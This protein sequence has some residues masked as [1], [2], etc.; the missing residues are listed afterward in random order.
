MSRRPRR[1]AWAIVATSFVLGI[2]Q[3]VA[4]AQPP[5]TEP[6]PDPPIASPWSVETRTTSPRIDSRGERSME[7][8]LSIGVTTTHGVV[9]RTARLRDTV[10]GHADQRLHGVGAELR[11]RHRQLLAGARFSFVAQR[12]YAATES[13]ATYGVVHERMSAQNV[14]LLLG[15]SGADFAIEGGAGPLRA[16]LDRA[17]EAQVL[18]ASLYL[19]GR[20]RIESAEAR[21]QLG[22]RDGFLGD[23]TLITL[24]AAKRFGR[25]ALHAD[26]GAGLTRMPDLASTP[27]YDDGIVTAA[28]AR[29][30]DLLVEVGMQARL[31]RRTHLEVAALVGTQLPRVVVGLRVDAIE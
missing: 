7:P 15:Y 6:L 9:R 31:G 25:V 10:R 2:G 26:L 21:F 13:Y 12:V 22:S 20:V 19:R 29:L 17:R 24:G 11:M 18:P 1:S 27:Q 16:R 8:T 30:V 3:A 14:T 4:A 28:R 23:P 5:S